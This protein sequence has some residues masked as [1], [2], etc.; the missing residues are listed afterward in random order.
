MATEQSTPA[1]QTVRTIIAEL[2]PIPAKA[3]AL[4]LF[5]RDEGF[6][7]FTEWAVNQFL[8]GA[9]IRFQIDEASLFFDPVEAELFETAEEAITSA[10]VRRYRKVQGFRITGEIGSAEK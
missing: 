8:R 10:E 6:P 9:S 1:P 4:D 2:E 3:R 7:S 5:A